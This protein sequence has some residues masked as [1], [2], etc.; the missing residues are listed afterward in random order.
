MQTVLENMVIVDCSLSKKGEISLT[1][2]FCFCLSLSI[3]FTPTTTYLNPHS[4]TAHL[5]PLPTGKQ[6]T[7]VFVNIQ[8]LVAF[9]LPNNRI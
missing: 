6:E 3:S 7:T 5:F 2:S 1:I 4:P 8:I 9:C